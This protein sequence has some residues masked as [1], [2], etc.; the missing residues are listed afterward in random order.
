MWKLNTSKRRTAIYLKKSWKREEEAPEMIEKP[1]PR[2]EGEG[3]LKEHKQRK[4]CKEKY[5]QQGFKLY[6]R[7]LTLIKTAEFKRRNHT[8]LDLLLDAIQNQL[9]QQDWG[10]KASLQCLCARCCLLLIFSLVSYHIKHL[11]YGYMISI[12]NSSPNHL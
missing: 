8:V 3:K 10:P 12:A 7:I 11:Y 1:K 4:T 6:P 2:K 5:P 9:C